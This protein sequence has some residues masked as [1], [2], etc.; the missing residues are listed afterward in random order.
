MTISSNRHDENGSISPSEPAPT[1]KQ[2]STSYY[3]NEDNTLVFSEAHDGYPQHDYNDSSSIPFISDGWH[4]DNKGCGN[5]GR[6]YVYKSYM[7]KNGCFSVYAV[8]ALF[9][10]L[11][12]NA[13]FTFL[14]INSAFSVF[15]VNSCF[16]VLS[17]NSFM[18]LG[19]INSAFKICLI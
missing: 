5:R 15:S 14:A 3:E 18:S 8:N 16:S 10:L 6:Y 9:S 11:A 17:V 2:Q 1:A 13:M 7:V 4:Y 19:C 12:I